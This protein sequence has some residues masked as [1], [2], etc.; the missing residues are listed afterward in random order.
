LKRH[1]AGAGKGVLQL[2]RR[3]RQ[4][5]GCDESG[6]RIRAAQWPEQIE[7]IDAVVQQQINVENVGYVENADRAIGDNVRGGQRLQ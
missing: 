3:G 5:G 1:T 6:A 2:G 4:T 7:S